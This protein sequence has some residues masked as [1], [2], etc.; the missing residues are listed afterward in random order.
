MADVVGLGSISP[1]LPEE[2]RAAYE[3]ERVLL[4]E[5]L[6]HLWRWGDAD[7]RLTDRLA[8]PAVFRCLEISRENGEA[9]ESVRGSLRDACF[10]SWPDNLGVF[11]ALSAVA[12][13]L[14][15][16]LRNPDLAEAPL[17]VRYVAELVRSA[18]LD[19]AWDDSTGPI[20]LS[21][22]ATNLAETLVLRVDLAELARR[23]VIEAPPPISRTTRP[24]RLT[25]GRRLLG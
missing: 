17:E 15:L 8:A 9:A 14:S 12:R 13:S 5:L 16:S 3:D 4:R 6:A 25:P 19:L 22:R 20:M 23:V 11:L 24:S 1:S 18:T 7:G 21:H 2:L 10:K